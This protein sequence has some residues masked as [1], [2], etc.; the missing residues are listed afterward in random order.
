M[1]I[2]PFEL[3]RVELGMSRIFVFGLLLCLL[4]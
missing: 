4:G 3:S 1:E 2:P